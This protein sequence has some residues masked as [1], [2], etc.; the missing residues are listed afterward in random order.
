MKTIFDPAHRAGVVERIL[1]IRPDS[2]R[3]W[4]TMTPHETVVH[5]ADA[6]STMLGDRQA[7]DSS[8]FFT[9]TVLRFLATTAP[10]RWPKGVQTLPEIDQEIGGTPPQEF[11]ADLR[12]LRTALHAFL[13]RLDPSTMRHPILGRLTRAEWGRWAYRHIDHHARQFGL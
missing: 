7:E 3:R 13:D 11:Q 8:T 2:P 12:R 6:F 9:R 1:R 10:V 5:L 4:G